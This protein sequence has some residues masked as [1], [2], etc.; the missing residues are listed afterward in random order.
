ME[1]KKAELHGKKINQQRKLGGSK[2]RLRG[3]GSPSC[4]EIPLNDTL[5]DEESVSSLPSLSSSAGSVNVSSPAVSDI[6]PTPAIF[7]NNNQQRKVHR[8][9]SPVPVCDPVRD[10]VNDVFLLEEELTTDKLEKVWEHFSDGEPALDDD[11]LEKLLIEFLILARA[12]AQRQITRQQQ[13]VAHCAKKISR[14]DTGIPDANHNQIPDDLMKLTELRRTVHEKYPA[15]GGNELAKEAGEAAVKCNQIIARIQRGASFLHPFKTILN[16]SCQ[17][18]RKKD[19]MRNFPHLVANLSNATNLQTLCQLA[20]IRSASSGANLNW[21]PEALA[22]GP[23][24][25]KCE[26]EFEEIENV[27]EEEEF[28]IP[29]GT[30]LRDFI[31]HLC[32]IY[33]GIVEFKEEL[34]I[35][36]VTA[37]S[38]ESA[39]WDSDRILLDGANL[40][41]MD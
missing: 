17:E 3:P 14:I 11:S 38:M 8:A 4:S 20:P 1:V 26:F 21:R 39:R 35:Q 41:L 10:L 29:E 36:V 32:I 22:V 6:A 34:D 31:N 13:A 37:E 7:V 23:V 30:S 27:P 33:E 40:V 24:G 9:Q 5:S 2:H 25:V 19:F 16:P 28:N 15:V 12:A 18:V